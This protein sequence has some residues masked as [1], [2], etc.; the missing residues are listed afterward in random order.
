MTPTSA[1]GRRLQQRRCG[2]CWTGAS[3]ESATNAALMLSGNREIGAGTKPKMEPLHVRHSFFPIIDANET[4]PKYRLS[5]ASNR[6]SPM[7]KNSPAGTVTDESGGGFLGDTSHA[8]SYETSPICSQKLLFPPP[9]RTPFLSPPR[10]LM[11]ND[12]PAASTF[13]PGNPITRQM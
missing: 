11:P 3:N 2:S 12:P 9:S 7:T 5:R 6:L 10:P 4:G 13:S 1:M 8:T